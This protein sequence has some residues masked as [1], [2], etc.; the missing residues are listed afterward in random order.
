MANDINKRIALFDKKVEELRDKMFPTDGNSDAPV[1]VLVFDSRVYEH[2]HFV[3][4][5]RQEIFDEHYSH[6]HFHPD[7]Q[8]EMDSDHLRFLMLNVD[9]ANDALQKWWKMQNHEEYEERRAR[10]PYDERI[11]AVCE[12][13]RKGEPFRHWSRT[14]TEWHS[15]EILAKY[16][17]YPVSAHES[18]ARCDAFK[19]RQYR[20]ELEHGMAREEEPDT[21]CPECRARLR[22]YDSFKKSGD[23]GTCPNPTC[24]K[25]T[26][27]PERK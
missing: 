19:I 8:A 14:Y 9:V 4:V 26:P 5:P 25:F 10:L 12:H 20:Y 16:P 23:K 11:K 6:L 1:A 2:H 27:Q 24:G 13:C 21:Y 22:R 3:P 15:P 7:R 17:D 18:G